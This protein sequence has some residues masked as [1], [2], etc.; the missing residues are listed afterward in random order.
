MMTSI[1][2]NYPRLSLVNLKTRVRRFSNFRQKKEKKF[3]GER[4][5]KSQDGGLDPTRDLPR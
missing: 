5:G 1:R 3:K 2:K 4:N